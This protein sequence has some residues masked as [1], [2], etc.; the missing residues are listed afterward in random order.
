[1]SVPTA[2]IASKLRSVLA[3]EPGDAIPQEYA[4]KMQLAM[5]AGNEPPTSFI[6]IRSTRAGGGMAQKFVSVRE[7]DRA[8]GA[9]S[10][11]AEHGDVFVGAAPRVRE[12]GKAEAVQRVWCLWADC[13]SDDSIERLRRFRPLPTI[14]IRSGSEDHLHAWW[15]LSPAIPPAI[16]VVAN[17]RL[18]YALAAD[19]KATDTPR[20]MRPS[21]T[22]N[23]KH[24]PPR[25]VECVRLQLDA[26]TLGQVVG[27][28]ADEPDRRSR[29]SALGAPSRQRVYPTQSDTP[30]LSHQRNDEA[31]LIEAVTR[32]VVAA[33]TG[34]RNDL[35]NW[36]AYTLGQH[37]SAGTVGVD[38]AR[39]GL[40]Q[41]ASA[42]GLPEDEAERTIHSGLEAGLVA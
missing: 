9:I 24:K 7:L 23:H 34:E 35:L 20:V 36:A 10:Y 32:K 16:A 31:V 17:R 28:L 18:A 2:S 6:E 29:S 5:I 26:F 19:P 40:L 13:D 12:S 3:F 15:Q 41:A 39:Q 38:D 27:G 1:M 30:R 33:P 11:I 4:L 25:A 42:V 14:L 8:L 37:V 21:G 22:L